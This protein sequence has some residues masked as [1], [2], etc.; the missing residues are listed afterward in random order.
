M[1]LELYS[2]ESL[3]LNNKLNPWW[4]SGF[5][6]GEGSFSYFT[7]SV[8]TQVSAPG[9]KDRKRENAAGNVVKDY[10]LAF[11]I[12]QKS[13]NLHVLNL[14]VNTLGMGKVYSETRGISKFR[15]VPIEQI[16]NDLVPFFDRYPLDPSVALGHLGCRRLGK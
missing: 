10:T 7:P 5:A 13:D 14:I 11:D 6:T 12:G 4:I 16:L 2:A 3:N 9:S 1:D 15:L 8:Q